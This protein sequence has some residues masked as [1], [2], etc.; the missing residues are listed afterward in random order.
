[1]EIVPD[2]NTNFPFFEKIVD[3]LMAFL[4]SG[5][6]T[7]SEWYLPVLGE[8]SRWEGQRCLPSSGRLFAIGAASPGHRPVTGRC[9]E[10]Q[11]SVDFKLR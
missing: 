6:R 1:M 2:L 8:L 11:A 5:C 10:S 9:V 4:L 3:I 7:L